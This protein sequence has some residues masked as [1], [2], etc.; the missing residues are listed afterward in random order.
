MI[1]LGSAQDWS[2]GDLSGGPIICS[3]PGP[4]LRISDQNQEALVR[5]GRGKKRERAGTESAEESYFQGRRHQGDLI[6][7]IHFQIISDTDTEIESVAHFLHHDGMAML[8]TDA[9][10]LS[11]KMMRGA[12]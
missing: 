6:F 8:R 7:W 2:W 3:D 10:F 11:G 5:A 4:F 12:E 1:H 9:I